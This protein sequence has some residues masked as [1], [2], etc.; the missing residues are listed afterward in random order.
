MDEVYPKFGKMAVN[1]KG[2]QFISGSLKIGKHES[3]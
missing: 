3:F 1:N 2:D